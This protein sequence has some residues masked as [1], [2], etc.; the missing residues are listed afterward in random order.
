[1]TAT[2]DRLFVIWVDPDGRRHVVGRLWRDPGGGFSFGYCAES[3][4]TALDA[5]FRS[6]MEFPDLARDLSMPYSSASLFATFRKR[7]P[8]AS[9]GDYGQLLA[10]W[11]IESTEPDPMEVLA[12]SG[13][14]LLTD[15][16]ELAEYRSKSD[17][18]A[19]P[20]RFRISGQSHSQPTPPVDPGR[21]LAL[22]REPEN[23]KDPYATIVLTLDDQRVG[24][25]PKQ[26][27]E[28]IARL[29]DRGVPL[30]AWAERQLLLPE[31]RGRW[32]VR[33]ERDDRY[34]LQPPPLLRVAER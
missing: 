17:D 34:R 30:R 31:N 27:S 25:V 9:R 24:W 4:S 33:V 18:L 16:L 20:L 13:G 10:G 23:P 22:R 32:V 28:L 8:A 11:G 1:M 6:L 15:D 26:Y 7:V 19:Q 29:L 21:E 3:L 2:Y 14:V 12:R 5:G